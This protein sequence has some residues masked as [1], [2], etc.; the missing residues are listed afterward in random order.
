MEAI[1]AA[2]GPVSTRTAGRLVRA[3]AMRRRSDPSHFDRR[4]VEKE[5]DALL[6]GARI[7]EL[8]TR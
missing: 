6:A 7:S 3:E 2:V 8:A 1:V 4:D 5:F